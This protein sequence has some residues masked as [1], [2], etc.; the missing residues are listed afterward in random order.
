MWRWLPAKLLLPPLWFASGCA[1]HN[2]STKTGLSDWDA[3]AEK[4][5]LH[6]Y[7]AK[8]RGDF[9]VVYDEYSGLNYSVGT[10]AFFMNQNERRS[11]RVHAPHFV[12]T[13]LA[14]NFPAIPV[15]GHPSSSGTNQ[16]KGSFAVVGINEPSFTI[17]SGKRELSSHQLPV[18]RDRKDAYEEAAD[19][20]F[21]RTGEITGDTVLI[22]GYIVLM[23]MW[24]L[25]QSGYAI[26]V[27]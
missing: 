13:N 27:H 14:I 5:N 21:E 3:P 9:L 24:S 11:L 4:T 19:T 7:D 16:M 26:T 15:I 17:Y 6:L 25:G 2:A 22:A 8:S 18:Y 20:A 1:I 23:G 12:R 10:R